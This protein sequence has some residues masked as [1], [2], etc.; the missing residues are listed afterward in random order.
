MSDY[1]GLLQGYGLT[2]AAAAGIIGNGMMESNMDPTIIQGGGSANEV[3]VNGTNGYGLFQWTDEGRQQ[4][5]ADFAKSLGISSGTPEAQIQYML[6]ELG[7]AGIN[8]LNQMQTPEDAAVWF[9]DNFEKSADTDL[10]GRTNAARQ[11]FS[12]A[13]SPTSMVRLQ[14]NNPH[15]QGFA[16]DDPNEKLDWDKIQ[17]LMNYQVASPEVEAARATQAGRIAGLRNAS[18][19]GEMGTALSKNNA[20][21]MKALVNESVS[22]ANTANNTQK[23]TNAGQLAQMIANSH[24]SSNSKMLASLGAAL[25][26]RLDPMA[27]RYMNNNQ[28]ALANMKRQQ[29]LDDQAIA[30]AQ[31][32]ELMN[33]QFQQ[34]KELQNA[35]M[36]QAIAVAGMRGRG[37]SGSKLPDGSYLGADGQP[38]L[39]I[40][41]Q[42]KVGKILDAGQADFTAASDA[43]WAKTSYDGWKGSVASTT[44]GIIDKLAPYSNTVEGQEAISKVLGWQ[45]YDQDAKTKAWGTEKQTAYTG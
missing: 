44:Q 12:Q 6:K 15:A 32:K 37:A 16:F 42:N 29:E 35:K 14:N 20:D 39:T 41:Q 33:M 8:A 25:G 13:G 17:T 10:S 34:Q 28:M 2:P 27:D 21:Q 5:L 38:H 4:G 30:F 24:N 18:Y 40:E 1:M 36:A 26:V 3:P 23:L 9:H 11:A 7:P 45:R 22:A 19:F 43:D 31:K